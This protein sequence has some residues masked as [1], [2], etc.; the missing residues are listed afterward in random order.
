MPRIKRQKPQFNYI[1]NQN[2]DAS[3]SVKFSYGGQ[4]FGGPSNLKTYLQCLRAVQLLQFNLTEFDAGTLKIAED[5]K[6]KDAA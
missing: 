6:L 5:L 1:I 2:T 4:N 3:W